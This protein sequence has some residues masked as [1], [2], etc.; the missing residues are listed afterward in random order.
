MEDQL[1]AVM[2]PR[3]RLMDVYRLLG[4]D[5]QDST[6]KSKW[7]KEELKKVWD[8]SADNMKR[9]IHMVAQSS[10]EISSKELMKCRGT[11]N[12]RQ[13]GGQLGSFGRRI[14]H[15]HGGKA[16]FTQRWDEKDQQYFYNMDDEIKEFFKSS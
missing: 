14:K 6:P 15:R 3:E 8:E 1:V 16:L 10:S 2:V 9:F 4:T 13:L 12:R 5:T 7:T 11:T